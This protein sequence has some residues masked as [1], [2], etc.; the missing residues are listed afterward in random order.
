MTEQCL[1]ALPN[2]EFR[3][4]SFS[5]GQGECVEIAHTNTSFSLRDSKH[6][7]SPILALTS[8]QGRALLA[9]LKSGQLPR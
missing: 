5:A 7:T 2:T 6:T 4:S 8:G 3:K 1:A 9:A